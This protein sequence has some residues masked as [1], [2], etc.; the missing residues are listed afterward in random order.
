[1]TLQKAFDDAAYHLLCRNTQAAVEEVGIEATQIIWDIIT[2]PT[3][4]QRSAKIVGQDVFRALLATRGDK[5]TNLV[6]IIRFLA[7]CEAAERAY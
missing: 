3:S 5:C 1:M 7:S 2:K 4:S 6:N